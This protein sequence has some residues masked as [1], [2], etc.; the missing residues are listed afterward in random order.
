MKS[1][2]PVIFQ[3]NSTSFKDFSV[4]TADYSVYFTTCIHL[5]ISLS[6]SLCVYVVQYFDSVKKS[7]VSMLITLTTAKWGWRANG[8]IGIL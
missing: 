4:Y 7:F 1:L 2:S 5:S 8:Q 3:W 6:R